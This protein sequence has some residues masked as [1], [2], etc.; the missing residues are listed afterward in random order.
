MEFPLNNPIRVLIA[1]VG[2]D[3]HDRGA[4]YITQG[5]R[6]AGMQVYYTGIRYTPEQIAEAAQMLDV[7]CV[8][9]SSLAGTH[10]HHF[11]QVVKHLRQRGLHNLTLLAGGIIP[12]SDFPLLYK[13][14]F[15][16]IYKPGASIIDIAEFIRSSVELRNSASWPV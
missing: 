11:P 5:L 1:K 2:L 9:L 15:A 7:H 16:K 14:G 3:G 6:E 4:L 13:E 8:G 10:L 12:D